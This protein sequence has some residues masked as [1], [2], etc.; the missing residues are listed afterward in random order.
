MAT[1]CVMVAGEVLGVD[2]VDKA[3][4]GFAV[5]GSGTVLFGWGIVV[6][7]VVGGLLVGVVSPQAL[8]VSKRIISIHPVVSF[9]PRLLSPEF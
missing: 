9:L 3:A 8:M 1:F 2:V 7:W 5:V 4:V 6:L